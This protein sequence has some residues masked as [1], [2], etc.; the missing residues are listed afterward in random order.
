SVHV[1]VAVA[2]VDDVE[3]RQITLHNETDRPR[4]LSVISAGRPV[5]L[6]AGQAP[7][8]PAFSSMFVESEALPELDGVLFNRRPQSPDVEAPVLVHRLVREGAAVTFAGYETERGSFFGRC[9]TWET[10]ASL[11][12]G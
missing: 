9:S 1:D 7:S 3:V 12:G 8:H 11:V 2:P 4:R 5:L 10:P 6:D